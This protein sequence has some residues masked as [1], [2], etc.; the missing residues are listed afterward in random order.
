MKSA[1]GRKDKSTGC[2]LLIC[3]GWFSWLCFSLL[4]ELR[5]EKNNSKVKVFFI[6]IHAEKNVFW[7]EKTA[8]VRKRAQRNG[9][10]DKKHSDW[11]WN[12]FLTGRNSYFISSSTSQ[13][14]PA[15]AFPL[16]LGQICRIQ[17]CSHENPPLAC[18]LSRT[19]EITKGLLGLF[20][21][22]RPPE[23]ACTWCAFEAELL[24]RSPPRPGLH[25]FNQSG[26]LTSQ[27]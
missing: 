7:K 1:G 12:L 17:S 18:F 14:K 2:L 13:V 16:S 26:V 6:S 4:R 22:Q 9:E 27:V 20:F 15:A 24:C 8:I 10:G 3:Q 19:G 11:G 5:L 25:L 23:R 21:F